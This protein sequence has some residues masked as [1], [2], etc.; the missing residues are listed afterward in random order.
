MTDLSAEEIREVWDGEL[1]PVLPELIPT[2]VPSATRE[3]LTTVGLP[4][5][6]LLAI[7][8]IRDDRLST[9]VRRDGAEYLVFAQDTTNSVFGVDLESERVY[10]IDRGRTV[11]Y[12]S[13]LALFVYFHGLLRQNVLSLSEVDEELLFNAINSVR[14]PLAERDPEALSDDAPWEWFLSEL[15]TEWE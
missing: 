7:S 1:Q 3:F 15:E 2:R 11:F 6:S 5:T 12:N 8:F 4:T 9:L 14:E 10:R 13:D